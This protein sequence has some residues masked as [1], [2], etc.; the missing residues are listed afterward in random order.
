LLMMDRGLT[1]FTLRK[2]P[3]EFPHVK[4]FVYTALGEELSFE[5]LAK[6]VERIGTSFTI[7][8]ARYKRLVKLLTEVRNREFAQATKE[9]MAVRENPNMSKEEKE[10]F[11]RFDEFGTDLDENF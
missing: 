10:W 5:S 3:E 2:G 1:D 4:E 11:G 7:D 6:S 9:A 8:V